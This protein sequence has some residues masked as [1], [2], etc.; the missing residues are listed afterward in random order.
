MARSKLLA[1]EAS[2]RHRLTSVGVSKRDAVL[3]GVSGGLDSMSLAMILNRLQS[4]GLF[5]HLAIAHLDHGLR[6][7]ESDADRQFVLSFAAKHHIEIFVESNDIAA[8]ALKGRIGVEEAGRNERYQFF[9]RIAEANNFRWVATAHHAGDVL[10]TILMNIARGT[11]IRGL[12]GVPATRVLTDKITIIRPLLDAS[13]E[14]IESY[15]KLK[16][17][18]WRED[19]SNQSDVYTRNRIRASVI[20]ALVRAM[21]DRDIHAAAKRLVASASE[22]LAFVR[23]EAESLRRRSRIRYNEEYF[24]REYS[25]SLSLDKLRVANN[26]VVRELLVLECE[27]LVGRPFSLDASAWKR[28]RSMI[29]TGRP[30]RTQLP[31]DLSISILD[32]IFRIEPSLKTVPIRSNLVL[33]ASLETEVGT[34]SLR[35]S[36]MKAGPLAPDRCLL[37]ASV[38]ADHGLS[39]RN[40]RPR[41]RMQPFGMK[42]TRLVS[43]ILSEAGVRTQALKL[44]FPIV[45]LAD[46]PDSVVWVPGIRASE[47]CRIHGKLE[48]AV[49]LSRKH[50]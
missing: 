5:K 36:R 45:V 32:N 49:L 27:A 11:G 26:V 46:E 28:V 1:I 2:V 6:G 10:E 35:K 15:A 17:I 33:G 42:G 30:K 43:D 22:I 21:G 8:L 13:K 31:N 24:V 50:S 9:R 14:E 47:R 18:V 20:P 41:D 23:E 38:L 25:R 40:W 4:Q 16:R 3:V 44:R 19:S 37:P 12:A 39:V 7:H 34:I 29:E 48:T